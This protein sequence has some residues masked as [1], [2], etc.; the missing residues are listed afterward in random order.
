MTK[1]RVNEDV[2]LEYVHYS[3]IFVRGI[4]STGKKGRSHQPQKFSV[5]VG[6]YAVVHYVTVTNAN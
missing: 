6:P 5:V 1:Y 4:V 3:Y 2:E